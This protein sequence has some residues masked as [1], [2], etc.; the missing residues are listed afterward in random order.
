MS[1]KAAVKGGH[2]VLNEPTDL[3]EGT[4]VELFA[5]DPGDDLDPS[6][7]QKL[8]DALSASETDLREGRLLSAN[9]V[10]DRLTKR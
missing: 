6:N 4:E 8:Y 5:L 2:L 10:L 9:D 3:P 7:R 1:L